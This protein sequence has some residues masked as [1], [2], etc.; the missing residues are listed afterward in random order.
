M[1]SDGS[2]LPDFVVG[3]EGGLTLA[4]PR[5]LWCMAWMAV[6]RLDKEKTFPYSDDTQLLWG[7][8]K[9]AS[10]LLPTEITRLVLDE[11][12]ELGLADDQVFSRTNSKHRGGTVGI[13]THERITR[14]QYYAHA[15]HLALIPFLFPQLY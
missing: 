5:Q 14:T 1:T 2:N 13:L 11:R 3:L 9:T 12:M 7:F 4:E 6:A 8:A 10:F 15:I